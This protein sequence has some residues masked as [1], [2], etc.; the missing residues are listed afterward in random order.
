ML[1]RTKFFDDGSLIVS[2]PPTPLPVPP[3]PPGLVGYFVASWP[4]LLLGDWLCYL[5][6]LA[7][8]LGT[9]EG[10]AGVVVVV[11]GGRAE[12]PVMLYLS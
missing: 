1:P 4:N 5:T 2:D 7:A 12:R 8:G 10:R 9:S 3:P 6:A 11:V